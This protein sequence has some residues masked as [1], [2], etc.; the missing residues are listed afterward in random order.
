MRKLSPGL[1]FAFARQTTSAAKASCLAGQSEFAANAGVAEQSAKA[2][3]KEAAGPDV[4]R[5]Y[6]G[7]RVFSAMDACF[8]PFEV[9][10]KQE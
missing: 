4:K 3:A 8:V 2:S 1:R 6:D 9:A 7:L 5:K 10:T